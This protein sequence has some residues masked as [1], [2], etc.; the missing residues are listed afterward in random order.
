MSLKNRKSNKVTEWKTIHG[1]VYIEQ[2]PLL[3]AQVIVF[4]N[5]ST[6]EYISEEENCLLPKPVKKKRKYGVKK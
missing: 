5:G 1:P 2:H 3:D 6:I 4:T